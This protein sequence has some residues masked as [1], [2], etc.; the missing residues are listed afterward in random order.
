M[1][2]WWA[3]FEDK[4]LKTLLLCNDCMTPVKLL[5]RLVE[6]GKSTQKSFIQF[7]V[8]RNFLICNACKPVTVFSSTLQSILVDW[9]KPRWLFIYSFHQDNQIQFDGEID[10]SSGQTVSHL[11]RPSPHWTHFSRGPGTCRPRYPGSS[12]CL[13]PRPALV[14]TRSGAPGSSASADPGTVSKHM[15]IY[16]HTRQ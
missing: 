9:M 16:I 10:V 13:P 6:M 2:G 15:Q 3:K 14:L 11:T 7:S 8:H 1:D 5:Q 4:K 12:C